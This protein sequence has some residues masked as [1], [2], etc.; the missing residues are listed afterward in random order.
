MSGVGTVHHVTRTLGHGD[1]WD[2]DSGTVHINKGYGWT[3]CGVRIGGEAKGWFYGNWSP[4][5]KRCLTHI[6]TRD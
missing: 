4:D 3:L 1:Y 5:C 6:G 2:M